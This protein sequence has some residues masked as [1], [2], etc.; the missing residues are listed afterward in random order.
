M[1][2]II[3]S[4]L[5]LLCAVGLFA[6]CDEDRDNNPV[7]QTPTHFVLN[8]PA[9]AENGVYDLAH[10]TSVNFTASQP[11]Y[12]FPASVQYSIAVATKSDMSN[13]ETISGSTFTDASAINIDAA[14]LAATLTSMEVAEGK[15]EADFPM[16]IPVYVQATA[17]PYNAMGS[18]VD[19]VNHSFTIKSNIVE[20]KHVHLEF[21][22]PPV[23]TPEEL[24]LVGQF[25]GWDWNNSVAM[26][27]V[28][29][30]TNIFWHMVWL[31]ESDGAKFNSVKAWNGSEV[32]YAKAK[33]VAMDGE[34]A[35][36]ANVNSKIT[37]S[38]DG[39][40]TASEEGWYLM[41]VNTSVSGRDII[42][43]V[44][45]FE[46]NVWLMGP[47]TAK[48]DWS[49]LEAAAKFT[50]AKTIDGEFVSPAFVNGVPGGDGDGVRAYVKI[51]GFDWW[52][53]EFIVGLDGDKIS[54][55]GNGGDQARVKGDAGNKMYLNFAKDTGR[56]E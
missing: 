7:I 31:S 34:D 19:S 10:S 29:S 55:R 3:K 12:G 32:G 47:I 53:S 9:M 5:L 26:T 52:K 24:Y 46:P 44:T 28:N 23:T 17:T 4:T 11:D 8:T 22:L 45:F 20:L 40:F 15:T 2:N 49:E 41:V 27:P 30:A 37:S 21:S 54:Y 18:E 39:N 36:T 50:P 48:G 25:C 13:A 1:K 42:Y 51:P 16:D 56:I 38:D 43:N 14:T 35:N 33:L 6:S